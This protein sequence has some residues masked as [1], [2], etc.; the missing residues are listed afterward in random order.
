LSDYDQARAIYDALFTP[1]ASR[2]LAR[3]LSGE[4]ATYTQLKRYDVAAEKYT[5]AI[6]VEARFT[7][8]AQSAQIRRNIEALET[9]HRL[10]PKKVP[11]PPDYRF[12]TPP[13]RDAR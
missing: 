13:E 10:A 7:L 11:P 3:V 5:E 2:E 12:T 6:A 1:D 4:A 8:G 9:L